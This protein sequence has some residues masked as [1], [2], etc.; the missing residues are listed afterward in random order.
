MKLIKIVFKFIK[1][2]FSFKKKWNLSNI[3]RDFLQ[4]TR[5]PL[6]FALL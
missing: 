4:I 6:I 3:R 1:G 2:I 5:I